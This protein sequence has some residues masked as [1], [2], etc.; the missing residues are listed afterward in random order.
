VNNASGYKG[1]RNL[2]SPCELKRAER[3]GTRHGYFLMM[4]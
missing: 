3:N 2:T 4:Q 1:N